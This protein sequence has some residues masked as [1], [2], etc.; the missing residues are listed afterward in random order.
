MYSPTE[1]SLHFV[2]GRRPGACGPALLMTAVFINGKYL[3]QAMTGVQRFAGEIVRALDARLAASPGGPVHY[4]LLCPPQARRPRLRC[5]GVRVV[6][7]GPVPLHLWEQVALPL[8]AR[9]GWLLNL[10]G[11]APLAGL[12]RQLCTLHDAA[13]FDHPQAY[14]PAF[15]LWYRQLFRAAA[16]SA[17]ALLT[18]SEFSRARLA[19]ALHLEPRRL[20]VVGEG[21]SH[22][23]AVVPDAGV[24]QRLG[25]GAAPFVLAVG[26][27]NPTKNFAALLR[28]FGRLQAADDVRLV[29]VGG[30]RASVFADEA[31][32][33]TDPRVLHAGPLDDAAIKALYGAARGLVFPSLYEGFGLPLAEAMALGCPVAASDIAPVRETCGEA[34]LYFD[35]HDEAAI[36]AALQALLALPEA[37]RQARAAAGRARARALDWAV[38]AARVETCVHQ[39]VLPGPGRRAS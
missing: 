28:A 25:V 7:A 17:G 10:A 6:S 32:A 20:A 3:A 16:R 9:S 1:K 15:G 22:L 2:A 38:A 19:E 21:A 12:P 29:V 23:D 27:R 11:A 8:A 26:S 24:L 18:V 30:S 33:S 35:P 36:A 14:T 37:E 39:L 4:T 5:I 31:A 34:A 13:V